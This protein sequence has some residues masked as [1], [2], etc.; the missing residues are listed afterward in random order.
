MPRKN[1]EWIPFT[2]IGV[3]VLLI[4]GAAGLWLLLTPIDSPRK[5]QEQ[6]VVP[7]PVPAATTNVCASVDRMGG[8]CTEWA[9]PEPR[10]FKDVLQLDALPQQPATGNWG[11]LYL[12]SYPP[13]DVIARFM[14]PDFR[15]VVLNGFT[16]SYESPDQDM[17]ILF[18][19]YIGTGSFESWT[20]ISPE[21]EVVDFHGRRVI[22]DHGV[23]EPMSAFRSW[24]MEIPG[25]P[26]NVLVMDYKGMAGIGDIGSI[27]ADK[28]KAD[29][30]M[31]EL[32]EIYRKATE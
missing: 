8:T 30:A 9:R 23:D 5:Q 14:G 10:P 7:P 2:I 13:E 27:P 26:N 4:G 18:D 3:V 29:Q 32:G 21:A 31:A 17:Q 16:C 6:A 19:V 15:R 20:D 25:A 11:A 12:C 22:V 24:I 1:R 28:A